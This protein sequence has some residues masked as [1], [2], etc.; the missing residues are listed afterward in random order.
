MIH[1]NELIDLLQVEKIDTNLY[2]GYNQSIGSPHIFGGQ[3]LAQGLYAMSQSVPEDRYCNSIQS[4]FILPGQLDKPIIFEVENIRDGGSFSVRRVLA[5]QNGKVIFFMSGS[6][7]IREDGYE[8]Q[9]EMPDVPHYSDLTS[10][11]ELFEKYKEFMPKPLREFLSI[12]RP[13]IFKPSIITNPMEPDK[14]PPYQNVWFKLKGETKNDIKLNQCIIAYIS[15]YNILATALQPNA[16]KAHMG[17]MQM[18]T[19][20][21]SMWF[22]RDFDINQWMLFAIDTPSA[23]NARGFTRGNIFTEKGEL[24]A[25]ITQEGLLR[26]I[27]KK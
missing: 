5:K 6:F 8:H 12:E 17:N 27:K 22:F 14:M 23:H 16:D 15:D 10:W 2:K 13:I 25:S 7:Q 26:P 24:I 18:A 19:L 21:H 3:V 4:Y 11:D 9:F 1:I 20:D